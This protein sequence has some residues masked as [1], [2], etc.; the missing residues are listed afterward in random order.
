MD[1]EE[2]KAK[3]FLPAWGATDD[4]PKRRTST[5]PR[6]GVTTPYPRK[7][8]KRWCGTWRQKGGGSWSSP[9]GER[10]GE[11]C[12]TK[13]RFDNSGRRMKVSGWGKRARDNRW[14]GGA[15]AKRSDPCRKARRVFVRK[16]ERRIG[17]IPSGIQLP[18]CR[19]EAQVCWGEKGRFFWRGRSESWSRMGA[20]CPDAQ[21][22]IS[23]IGKEGDL[24]GEADCHAGLCFT[25]WG[26]GEKRSKRASFRKQL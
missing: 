16:G 15:E 9:I 24:R 22:E 25:W 14:G 26:G 2:K 8:G 12:F 1:E 10:E 3:A 6:G 17:G 20:C 4:S 23:R 11:P 5:S 18:S 19:A 7:E 21:G 13:I